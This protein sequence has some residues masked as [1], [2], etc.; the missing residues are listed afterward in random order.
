[1]IITLVMKATTKVELQILM[2]MTVMITITEI[3]RKKILLAQNH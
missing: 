2:P 3:M 1:M